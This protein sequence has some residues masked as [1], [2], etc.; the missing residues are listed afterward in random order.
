MMQQTLI[1]TLAALSKIDSTNHHQPFIK[2]VEVIPCVIEKQWNETK[3]VQQEKN[4]IL[5]QKN[6][7]FTGNKM[8]DNECKKWQTRKGRIENY[9]R[10]W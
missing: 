5:T 6:G 9:P 7:N 8:H 2:E 3:K 1:P 4:D 10:D